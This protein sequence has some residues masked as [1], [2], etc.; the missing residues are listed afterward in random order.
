MLLLRRIRV[1]LGSEAGSATVEYAMVAFVAACSRG[2]SIPWK[3][4]QPVTAAISV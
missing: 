2:C 4:G 1:L 3:S